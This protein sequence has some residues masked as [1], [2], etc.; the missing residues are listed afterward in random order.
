MATKK[1]GAFDLSKFSPQSRSRNSR[2]IQVFF[3]IVCEGEKTEKNYFESFPRKNM[4]R[5]IV[6]DC[7]DGNKK[8][9]A[10]Q[11]VDKAI[12]LKD[13]AKGKYDSIWAVFDKDENSD[14]SFHQ[15]IKK[16]TDNGI[17]TAWS[18]ECFELWFIL[19]F[20]L[21]ET[22]LPRKDYKGIIE[23]AISS[24]LK[25]NAKYTYDKASD[26]IYSDMDIYGNQ[27]NAIRNA[28]KL[29]E[30]YNDKKYASHNPCTL[31]FKLVEELN[32]TSKE[33]NDSL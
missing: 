20:Q 12:E 33:L 16:A 29:L 10:M 15:A 30:K 21:L 17:K 23:K 28:K 25:R 31:V 13:K 11:I 24:Q 4:K 26:K 22:S 8:T 1:A 14:D 18:N 19:H 2:D 27:T 3:L 32:G 6:I 7:K 5:D 9:S